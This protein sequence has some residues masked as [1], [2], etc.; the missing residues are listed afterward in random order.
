M[1]WAVRESQISRPRDGSEHPPGLSQAGL[2]D[3]SAF[4]SWLCLTMSLSTPS[5]PQIPAVEKR[6]QGGST[7]AGVLTWHKDI[8]PFSPIRLQP[9]GAFVGAKVLS[10]V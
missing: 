4:L 5:F 1:G 7:Q 8:E 6:S 10:R 2:H 3:L 9:M